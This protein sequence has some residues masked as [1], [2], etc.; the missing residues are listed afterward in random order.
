MTNKTI[1]SNATIS[2]SSQLPVAYLFVALSTLVLFA[3]VV[4]LL[5]L[6]LYWKLYGQWEDSS[7]G[8]ASGE[9]DEECSEIQFED[10]E[11]KVMVILAGEDKPTCLGNPAPCADTTSN[12][13]AG[14]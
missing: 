6:C 5:L 1:S 12:T 10:M 9:G 3:S 14:E 2:T 7:N 8:P 13:V 4:F 11:E